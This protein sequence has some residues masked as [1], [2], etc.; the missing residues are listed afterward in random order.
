MPEELQDLLITKTGSNK[1][2]LD[3]I[4]NNLFSA[5]ERYAVISKKSKSGSASAVSLAVNIDRGENRS[6]FKPCSFLCT[7]ASKDASHPLNKCRVFS[8]A[9]SKVDQ[10]KS[11]NG[12]VRCGQLNHRTSNCLFKFKKD[13]F[14]HIFRYYPF[15]RHSK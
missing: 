10:I 1:P 9:R 4:Q 2:N 11:K 8:D 14:R 12:C 7:E 13:C 5:A 6:K 3:E 15:P